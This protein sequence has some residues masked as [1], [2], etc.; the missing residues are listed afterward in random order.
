M[1]INASHRPPAP[2]LVCSLEEESRL[3]DGAVASLQQRLAEARDSL[4]RLEESRRS[5]ERD[6]DCKSHSLFI[7][8][9]K[10]LK[11]RKRY[12]TVSTLLGY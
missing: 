6:V 10:C 3:L 2:L 8:R 11:Q 7:E 9:D 5:L 4:S 12:P 1:H